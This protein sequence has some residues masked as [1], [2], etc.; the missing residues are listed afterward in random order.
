MN[1]PYDAI[2]IGGG[3]NGGAIAF[4]LAKRGMKVLLLEKDRLA[5]KASGAAAGML[6]AQAELDGEGPLFQLARTSRALFNDL[7]DE[8]NMISGV[9]I[10]LVKKGMLRVALTDREQQEHH[11]ISGIHKQNG[12][13]AELLTGEEA[14]R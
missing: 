2:I 6:G 1:K 7:A 9:D 10:E 13:L 4:N 11:R 14:R 5:S 8:L 3:V 12:E